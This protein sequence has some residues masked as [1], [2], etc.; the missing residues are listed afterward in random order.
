MRN[1]RD[2]SAKMRLRTNRRTDSKLSEV[3][4]LMGQTSSR[5]FR[6]PRSDN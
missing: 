1:T 4:R 6:R 3:R 2:G 5:P